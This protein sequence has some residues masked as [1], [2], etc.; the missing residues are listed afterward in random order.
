M[1]NYE[2]TTLGGVPIWKRG[3]FAYGANLYAPGGPG[4]GMTIGPMYTKPGQLPAG[5]GSCS[6]VTGGVRRCVGAPYGEKGLETGRGWPPEVGP[7]EESLMSQGC[8]P[9]GR[10]CGGPARAPSQEW[11]CPGGSMVIGS[12]TPPTMAGMG[13]FEGTPW[14]MIPVLIAGA[15]MFIGFEVLHWWGAA[16]RGEL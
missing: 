7:Q 10:R 14:W 4:G 15:G 9:T 1:S 6:Q 2:Y 13:I 8:V 5:P 3:Q 11:C 16:Q 12:P